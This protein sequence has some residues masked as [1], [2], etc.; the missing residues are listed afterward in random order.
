M[1]KVRVNKRTY[2]K[3]LPGDSLIA[4]IY[5]GRKVKVYRGKMLEI[6]NEKV[7]ADWEKRGRAAYNMEMNGKINDRIHSK[8]FRVDNKSRD[9]LRKIKAKITKE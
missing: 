8:L 4:E 7:W 5:E 1:K 6:E 2:T 3:L 9:L